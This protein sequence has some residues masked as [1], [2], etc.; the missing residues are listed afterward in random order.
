MRRD[1]EMVLRVDDARHQGLGGHGNE[2]DFDYAAMDAAYRKFRDYGIDVEALPADRAAEL[3]RARPVR[4]EL[5]GA[6][7][8]WAVLPA[9]ALAD[10]LLAVARA[11]DPD[12]LRNRVRDALG[13]GEP[14]KVR[15]AELAASLQVRTLSPST[16]CA[17]GNALVFADLEA[18][19][20]ALLRDAQQRH[21]DDFWVNFYLA[22]ALV[23]ESPPPL[24]EII[25]FHSAAVALR[26]GSSMAAYCLGGA[27]L[28]KGRPEEAVVYF[29]RAIELDPGWGKAHTV[30]GGAL[31]LTGRLGEAIAEFRTAVA[32]APTIPMRHYNLGLA[33]WMNGQRVEAVACVRRGLALRGDKGE[34][35][36]LLGNALALLGR[37]NDAA[38]A[39]DVALASDPTSHDSWCAAALH[40]AVGDL[41]GYRRTCRG[42][43]GRFGDAGQPQ[44][45]GRTARACLLLPG[46]LDAA[47]FDRVQRLAER[48]VTGTGKDPSYRSFVLA[49]GLADYRAGRH[50]D[51]VT[52]LQR[53]APDPNG[54]PSDATA[55]A[56][57]ALAQHG[58][59]RAEEA[60]ASLAGAR[61]ILTTM[62]DLAK[63][64]PLDAGNWQDWVHAQVLG[65]EA[66]ALLKK[67]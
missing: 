63:G 58:L 24:D 23:A 51:A 2:L 53:F 37:W 21:L 49:K 45:A 34:P 48:A 30:L 4:L 7:D 67:K 28:R 9:A 35:H 15:L 16:L 18:D 40:A 29:R 38:A 54:A 13:S 19:A 43:L 14:N 17:L 36:F 46:A 32:L 8:A 61:A 55:F 50:A 66:E 60:R 1:V 3:I 27:L 42:M 59:G 33:L 25:R 22:W 47:D 20:V 39:F 11:S 65:R 62:P 56:V 52:W 26:P 41:E 31:V 64:R 6:L 57:L 12:E 10:K 5:T 44:A